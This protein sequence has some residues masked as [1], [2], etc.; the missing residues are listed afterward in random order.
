M[1]GARSRSIVVRW[2]VL[3]P[4]RRFAGTSSDP[5]NSSLVLR[6]E[7]GGT[8]VLLTGDVE[9]EAQRDLLRLGHDLRADVLKVPHHGSRHQE[10]AFLDAVDPAVVITSVG[11]GNT[12]GHPSGPLLEGLVAAGARSFRTDLDGDVWADLGPGGVS[13]GAQSGGLAGRPG[14]GAGG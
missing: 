13:V 14:C 5:N 6:V 4:A 12:Y 8:V 11:A 3:A 10:P 2:T 9:P 1:P 7:S